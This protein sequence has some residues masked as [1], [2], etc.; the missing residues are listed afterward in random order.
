MFDIK[1]HQWLSRHSATVDPAGRGGDKAPSGARQLR[2]L[3]GQ[4]AAAR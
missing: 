1:L 4:E 3:L 2:R